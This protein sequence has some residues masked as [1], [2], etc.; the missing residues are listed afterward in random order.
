MGAMDSSA[1]ADA[2]DHA[3]AL[4]AQ[5]AAE[6]YVIDEPYNPLADVR[7]LGRAAL[8]WAQLPWLKIV[9]A[10]VSLLVSLASLVLAN[11]TALLKRFDAFV[12]RKVVRKMRSRLAGD[13]SVG[14][15][16]VRVEGGHGTVT[17]EDFTLGNPPTAEFSSPFLVAMKKVHVKLNPLSILG[18]RGRGNF[19]VGYLCG[20]VALMS[21]TG[22]TVYVD[23]VP[24]P[25][26]GALSTKKIR[27]FQNLKRQSAAEAAKERAAEEA[28][29]L[30]LQEEK[31]IAEEAA[32][33]LK[34]KDPEGEVSLFSTIGDTFSGASREIERQ[35]AEVNK[36]AASLG[37]SV[38]GGIQAAGADVTNRLNALI[39]LL[40]RVNQKPPEETEEEKRK[41]RKLVLELRRLEFVDWNI[42][43][44][45]VNAKPFKF[46]S[47]ELKAFKG[48]IGA[49]ARECASGLLNEIILD[50]Q[51]EIL[52]NLTKDIKSV[53]DGLLNVGGTVVGGGAYVVGGI[54]SGA[55]A[56]GQGLVDTGGAIGKGLSDTGG[57][58][59]KGLSD[60]GEVIG[61]G[62]SDTG[63]VIGKGLT[64]TTQAVTGFFG[65][66]SGGSA[67]TTTETTET[68]QTTT[69]SAI[70]ITETTTSVSSAT[71]AVAAVSATAAAAAAAEARAA[72]DRE[73]NL[74][75]LK[76]K[77]ER[78]AA[79][80]REKEAAA[81]K[82]EE[83]AAA[84]A[85]AK[86][87]A[88]L[89]REQEKKRLAEEKAAARAKAKLAEEER[90]A[91]AAIARAEAKAEAAAAAA[92]AAAEARARKEA[93]S[94][95]KAAA[96]EAAAAEAA[97]AAIADAEAAR[98]ASEKEQAEKKKQSET[99]RDVDLAKKIA[100]AEAAIAAQ[101]AARAA[102]ESVEARK[103]RNAAEAKQRAALARAA[104]SEAG[105]GSEEQ[106]E[107]SESGSSYGGSSY[108]GSSYG[109]SGS[110]RGSSRASSPSRSGSPSRSSPSSSD[111]RAK[112]NIEPYLIRVK[113]LSGVF[114]IVDMD[115]RGVIKLKTFLKAVKR[116]PKIDALL[117]KGRNKD[118]RFAGDAAEARR[119]FVFAAL[120]RD[121][122]R[123]VTKEQFIRY[124]VWEI[125]RSDV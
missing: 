86:A 73:R 17:V 105:S 7:W 8:F 106:S 85:V 68:T 40:E 94:A 116:V 2:V 101:R 77:E 81:K 119:A 96:A 45:A 48:T 123:E 113:Y 22:A 92:K 1:I 88:A 16:K 83:E 91:A 114:D 76:E 35:L 50:F 46:K 117:K 6:V 112:K 13:V 27:N 55:G 41:R 47:W 71:V 115:K 72:G 62:L 104:V 90:I 11:K 70:E 29:L 32:K 25:A 43:I 63:E 5:A 84:R 34:A 9:T 122:K 23:E 21:V 12:T 18:V 93:E 124:F 82:K 79:R 26:A 44:L 60:T 54:A 125:A 39:T 64:D 110:S 98:E 87:E 4:L 118:G 51:N 33:N 66:S 58:I 59:G 19:V 89:A 108:G 53:G 28:A 31:R 67:A 75:A 109:G 15:V 37:S 74:A 24:D 38:A 30:L 61:K 52:E 42:H 99:L 103:R 36:Q 14:A 56:I 69:T 95:A 120:E 107:W 100:D 97:A 111:P 80:R 121:R 102:A 3:A 49:L 20:E 10:L 78:A 65:F 57:A